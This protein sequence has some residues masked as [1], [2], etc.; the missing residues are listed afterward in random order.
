V[1]W[2]PARYARSQTV[3]SWGLR[4]AARCAVETESSSLRQIFGEW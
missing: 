2:L 3:K 4:Q 1:P